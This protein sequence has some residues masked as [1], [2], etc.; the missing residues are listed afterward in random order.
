MRALLLALVLLIGSAP[1]S[2]RAEIDKYRKDRL[3][4]LTAPDGWLAVQGLFWL[5]DGANTA[6]SDPSS[7]IRLPGRLSKILR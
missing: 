6:G 2:W 3:E 4:E 7:E 5:H 1:D